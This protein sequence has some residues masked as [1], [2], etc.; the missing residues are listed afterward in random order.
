MGF[1]RAVAFIMC[2]AFSLAVGQIGMRMAVQANVR[3]AADS[4]HSLGGTLRTTYPSGPLTGIKNPATLGR[5]LFSACWG[6]RLTPADE[7]PG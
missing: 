4:R 3:G 7:P 2:A 5:T 1:G 6:R